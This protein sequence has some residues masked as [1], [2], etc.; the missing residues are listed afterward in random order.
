MIPTRKSLKPMRNPLNLARHLL[1]TVIVFTS[2][3]L[4][5]SALAVFS[6]ERRAARQNAAL[7]RILNLSG[8]ALIPS[9]RP[10]RHADTAQ[11]RI[12]WR[13]S[14]LLP[15]ISYGVNGPLLPLS[16]PEE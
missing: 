15:R 1:L 10:L 14:P 12:D 3:C 5:F 11:S 6:P 7:T 13:F 4:A 8:P 16:A 2:I 9:G